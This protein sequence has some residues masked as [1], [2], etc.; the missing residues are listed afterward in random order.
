MAGLSL[1]HPLVFTFGLL[2]N[3]ISF[4]V[5][6]SPIPTFYHVYRAKSTQGFQSVPY[7]VALF[8][9]MLW[10]YYA[11]VKTNSILLITI[12]VF[13]CVIETIYI[14]IYLI[15]APRRA[16]INTIV[17]VLL[18]NVVTFSLIILFILLLATGANRAKVLGWICVGFSISVFAAP[19]SVIRLVIRTRSVEFMPFSLS[20]FL[21]LSAVVW[22][23]YGLFKKDLYVQLPNVLGF[24]FG[25]V[26]M[27]LYLYYRNPK[28]NVKPVLPENMI[29]LPD[30]NLVAIVTLSPV[31][32]LEV[33]KIESNSDVKEER[34]DREP[35]EETDEEGEEMSPV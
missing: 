29:Q 8:S 27:T 35:K 5:Y 22:F 14:I 34:G 18:L 24:T 10:I 11:L 31:P 16:R 17:F 25:I 30:Q 2:G 33:R 28:A 32:V 3:I 1:D 12:N 15:Y 20:F 13:G 26:Q 23:L 7:I 21:T 9:A 4:M 19:L 6:L